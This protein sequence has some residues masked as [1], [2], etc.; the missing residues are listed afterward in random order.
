MFLVG[1]KVDSFVKRKMGIVYPTKLLRQYLLLKEIN[2]S[3][4]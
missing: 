3:G 4:R 1:R 2:L